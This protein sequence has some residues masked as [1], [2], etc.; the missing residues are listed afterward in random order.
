MVNARL[1]ETARQ[2]F[3]FASSRH[4]DFL[5][6]ETKTLKSFEC[7]TLSLAKNRDSET[8]SYKKR[9]FE[10]HITAEKT[11]LRNLKNSTK[12]L[13]VL[14]PRVF[15][16]PFATPYYASRLNL[17]TFLLPFSVFWLMELTTFSFMKRRRR[18]KRK[19]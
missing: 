9:D 2:G 19:G 1:C 17:K 16:G 13:Q 11:R 14:R 7:E 6:C 15:E 3:F 8:T 10:T 4:L 18:E 5:D 12:I